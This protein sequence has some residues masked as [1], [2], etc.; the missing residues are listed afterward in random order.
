MAI[1]EPHPRQLNDKKRIAIRQVP[2]PGRHP[3][4]TNQDE[5][6]R[7][8]LLITRVANRMKLSVRRWHSSA[9]PPEWANDAYSPWTGIVGCRTTPPAQVAYLTDL[10][11]E[12]LRFLSFSPKSCAH[13]PYPAAHTTS[14]ALQHRFWNGIASSGTGNGVRTTLGSPHCGSASAHVTP[15]GMQV[16]REPRHE[17]RLQ[18]GRRLPAV[19]RRS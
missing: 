17:R 16:H 1:G 4:A 10:A 18:P 9:Q 2:R 19:G 7:Q 13:W 14:P 5:R 8:A 3:G 11:S 6:S 15:D 12:C